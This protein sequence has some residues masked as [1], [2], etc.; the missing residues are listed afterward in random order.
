[1]RIFS[2]IYPF[3]KN[4]PHT[5][6]CSVYI[7]EAL[8][9]D[10]FLSSD[11]PNVK[12]QLREIGP[13]VYRELVKHVNVSFHDHNGTMSFTSVRHVEFL[14]D[15]NEPGILNRSIVVPNFALIGTLSYLSDLSFLAKLAMNPVL[16]SLAEPLFVNTTVYDLL[17]NFHSGIVGM[18]NKFIPSLVPE[19]NL[20]ILYGASTPSVEVVTD[21][22]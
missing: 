3:W 16:N 10:E 8:N 11:D 7:F 9:A 6:T 20:G 19:T 4:P 18:A 17:W 5:I 1:M 15:H 2:P 14:E 21:T 13:I 12:L 22:L